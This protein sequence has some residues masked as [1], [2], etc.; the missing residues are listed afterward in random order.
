MDCIN[1][2]EE[3][4]FVGDEKKNTEISTQ[5]EHILKRFFRKKYKCLI[6]YGLLLYSFL[7]SVILFIEKLDSGLINKAVTS[8]LKTK[9]DTLLN[10]KLENIENNIN[11]LSMLLQ[12]YL[13]MSI[14][15]QNEG[16]P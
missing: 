3:T 2:I 12:K 1:V 9:N 7:Q 10:D 11:N 16:N 15:S 8:L 5:K 6:I 13:N 14:I 4:P